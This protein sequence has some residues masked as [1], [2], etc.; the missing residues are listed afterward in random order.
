[1]AAAAIA[2]VMYCIKGGELAP[3]AITVLSSAAHEGRRG[4]CSRRLD[5]VARLLML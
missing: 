4:K 2:S 3:G 1:M 5:T